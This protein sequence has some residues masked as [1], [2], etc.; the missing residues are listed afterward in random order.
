MIIHSFR[1]QN[2]IPH[3]MIIVFCFIFFLFL[4]SCRTEN[5]NSQTKKCLGTVCTVN[6][7]E[8]GT[9]SLYQ[10]IFSRLTQIENEFSTNIPSSD[11]S[12]I[13]QCA[14]KESVKVSD[15]V[16]FVLSKALYYA[17][18]S[19]GAFDPTVGPLVK[20]W[21]INTDSEKVPTQQEIDETLKLINYKEVS[22]EGNCVRLH[23]HNMALDLGGI[24]KGFAADEIVKI[25]KEKNVKKA[26]IDLGGN[27]YIY[28]KKDTNSTPW[29]I[30]IKD[31]VEP[32]SAPALAVKFIEN[33][34]VVTSGIYERYFIS[35][36]KQ[37]HHILSTSNG[38]PTESNLLSTTIISDCSMEADALSTISF[39]LGPEKFLSLNI[40]EFSGQKNKGAIFISKEKEVIASKNLSENLSAFK[41]EY[42]SIKFR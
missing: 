19:E 22:I 4:T 26:V 30:A 28:G 11:I 6:L 3:K 5:V 12:R 20:L 42:E 36:G 14:G 40:R 1:I 18:I 41:K 13:N 37:F 31:P 35:E 15:D 7:F 23:R 27:I 25:L 29:N 34:T 9:K 21:G 32:E 39:I 24:A 2:K 16:I 38:Y 10:K 17:E 33:T 8:D